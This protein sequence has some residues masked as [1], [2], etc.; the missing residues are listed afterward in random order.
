MRIEI[1]IP[2]EFEEHFK[3]DKFKDSLE[4]IMVDIF[5]SLE[6]GNCLCAGRYE[7]ETIE[8]LEKALENS[9]TAY[10]VNKVVEEI[11]TLKEEAL[12]EYNMGEYNLD[13]NIGNSI[14]E[15]YRKDMNEGKCFAYDEAI[16]I[17]KQ[18]GVS[19]GVCEWEKYPFD[20]FTG[21]DGYRIYNKQGDYCPRCG[22]RIKVKAAE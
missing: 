7:Y 6:N 2:K 16:E 9:K 1:E 13:N 10:D 15:N 22:K 18:G 5:H 11:K 12:G 21:C 20:W 17:V 8:M 4:R 3:Q 14:S 19:D